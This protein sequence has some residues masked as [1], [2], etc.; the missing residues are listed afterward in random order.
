M[1]LSHTSSHMR[2]AAPLLS[3]ALLLLLSVLL[4]TAVHAGA[5]SKK[6][7]PSYL[8]ST[9][10]GSGGVYTLYTVTGCSECTVNRSQ[11]WCPTT[12]RC[13]AADN[14]TC[15][16]PVPCIDLR[17]CFYGSRPTCRECVDSGGVYCAGGASALS[18]RDGGGSGGSGARCY[19]PRSLS[20]DALATAAE[21]RDGEASQLALR[22]T[23]S[24]AALPVCD[25]STCQGGTCAVA[26]AECPAE[27]SDPLMRSYEV[28]SVMAVLVLSAMV[29][30]NLGRLLL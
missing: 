1:S 28:I 18:P 8:L 16:G 26:A 20:T 9:V 29:I 15:E 2:V 10:G 6:K 30:R 27:E 21:K 11:R 13:Y 3:S 22:E 14:C 5:T 4:L 24:E 23:P 7:D 12:M 17:T 25:V 19:P